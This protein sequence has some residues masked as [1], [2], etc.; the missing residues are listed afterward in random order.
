MGLAIHR[1]ARRD[2]RSDV[3][4]RVAN[5]VATAAPLEVQRLVEVERFGRI[6]GDERDGRLVSRRQA[7]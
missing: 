4:D 5:P 7:R 2:V 1:P 6:D 3:G